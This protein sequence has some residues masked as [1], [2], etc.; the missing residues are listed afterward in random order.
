MPVLGIVENMSYFV[1]P[2]CGKRDAHLRPRRRARDGERARRADFLGEIPL[3]IAIRET[4][5]A[6]TPIVATRP[7]AEEATSSRDRAK[8]AGKLL[9]IPARKSARASSSA[10]NIRSKQ[11]RPAQGPAGRK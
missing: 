1:C 5:D 4:S 6:G 7:Q 8:G 9:A 11:N 2:H 3:D 10:E